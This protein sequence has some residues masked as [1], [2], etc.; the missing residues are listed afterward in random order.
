MAPPFRAE[1]IGSL[2]RPQSLIEARHKVGLSSPSGPA[3]EN[4]IKIQNEAI[5]AVVSQQLARSTRPITSGEYERKI[6]YSDFFDRLPASSCVL[7]YL[8]TPLSRI[9]LPSR[10]WRHVVP[11]AVMALYA[12]GR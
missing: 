12:L 10:S 7:I 6:F 1:H 3:Q 11:K 4:L 5:A 8:S 2:L 9:S